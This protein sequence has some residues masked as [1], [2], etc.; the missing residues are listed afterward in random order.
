MSTILEKC[1]FLRSSRSLSKIHLISIR[2]HF[3]VLHIKKRTSFRI[4]Y[5]SRYPLFSFEFSLVDIENHMFYSEILLRVHKIK[6]IEENFS[7]VYGVF[8]RQKLHA[9]LPDKH[10]IYLLK[11]I[12]FHS[13]NILIRMKYC[14]SYY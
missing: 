8:N 6:D 13:V 4:F 3:L 14:L 12:D 1:S 2:R 9:N 11:M 7:L 5:Y 10:G